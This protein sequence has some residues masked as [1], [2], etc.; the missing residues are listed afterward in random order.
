[1]GSNII[2]SR[3][4]V[5]PRDAN[6]EEYARKLDSQDPM[7]S[8]RDKFIIPTKDSLKRKQLEK[9]GEFG[10]IGGTLDC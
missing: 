4:I 8:F 9:A 10:P 1:M 2:E 7:R 3:K 5:F 6:T